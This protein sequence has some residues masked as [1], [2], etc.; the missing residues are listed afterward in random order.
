MTDAGLRY[1]TFCWRGADE[2][3][4]EAGPDGGPSVLLLPPLF[5]ELNR[6]RALIAGIMRGLAAQGVR[7]ILPDLPGTGE[8]PRDLSEVD[9]DDWTGAASL[10]VDEQQ[11]GGRPLV[12]ASIRGGCLL[13]PLGASACWRFAPAAGVALARDLIRTRQA[14]LPGKPKAADIEAEA[15]SVA[16][17]FA[18]YTVPAGLFARLSDAQIPASVPVRTVRLATDATDAELKIEGKPLW[19]QAEPGND[20]RLAA[21]LASD[22]AGWARACAA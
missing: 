18:G 11:E 22:L 12:V 6:C 20:P 4:A 21:A 3:L 2:W 1:R 9:W 5:E 14:A 19:R 15:R 13:E 8:S 10:L 16:T 17:E 7:A